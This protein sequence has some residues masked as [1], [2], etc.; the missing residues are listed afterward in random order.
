M[1]Q[2][3]LVSIIIPTYNREELIKETLQSVQNQ[4]YGDWEC[5]IVDDGSTDNTNEILQKVNSED[6]RFKSFFNEGKKGACGAR[7][8]GINKSK[9]SFIIFLDSDDLLE[10]NCL[11]NR[12]QKFQHHPEKD[13]IVFSTL[14]FYR[15]MGDSNILINV[16][17]KKEEDIL[18][19]F[20]N[21]DVPWL[22]TGPIWKKKSLIELGYWNED[23]L[24]YQDWELHLRAILQGF[25]YQ[26]FT[27]I[28]NYWRV[29]EGID[30]IGDNSGDYEH[31]KSHIKLMKDLKPY[32]KN[33]P[34][35]IPLLNKLVAWEGDRALKKG[36]KDLAIEALQIYK[37]ELN[38]YKAA[39][40]F[41]G[42]AF[43]RKLFFK[44]SFEPTLGTMRSL[45]FQEEINSVP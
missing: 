26:H 19:R 44:L 13:F 4:T 9:G 1:K 5:L 18:V 15:N 34:L 32:F 3:P 39:I 16:P 17:T 10:A 29:N 22:S 25:S 8:T 23:I 37:E 28:D 20:L 33:K 21:L 35:H 41:I 11:K 2:R 42:L 7:N 12:L 6:S 31:L 27:E 45:Y 24:S 36:Y 40:N 14:Q 30:S 43:F 38:P